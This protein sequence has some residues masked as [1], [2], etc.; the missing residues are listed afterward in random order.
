MKMLI[1]GASTVLGSQVISRFKQYYPEIQISTLDD[2]SEGVIND[3]F[4]MH[5]F[6]SVIHLGASDIPDFQGT[7]MLLDAA[8]A[9]WAGQHWFRR[10]LYVSAE[11]LSINEQLIREY[12]DM[13]LVI[14]TCSECFASS[15]FPMEHIAL[16]NDN[17]IQNKSVPLYTH[18]QPVNSWFWVSDD[19]CA[20]DVIFNQGEAG[21]I[22]NIGGM[23]TWRNPDTD[24]KDLIT[25]K[26]FA[27]EPYMATAYQMFFNKL[28]N[29]FGNLTI[30]HKR[31]A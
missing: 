12:N 11:D 18:G 14:S 31:I 8:N 24:Y 21:L 5:K 20:I 23:N 28:K 1:T 6:E 19:A 10:F 22:Y 17:M 4:T 16:A 30:N 25:S 3:L 27:L 15:D 7:K 9:N 2:L 26:P 29:I 13:T